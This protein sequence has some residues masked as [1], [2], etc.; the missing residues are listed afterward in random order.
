[1]IPSGLFRHGEPLA[2]LQGSGLYKTRP[3]PDAGLSRVN[4]EG[5][6]ERSVR[7]RS[8]PTNPAR[9]TERGVVVGGVT[10]PF[11]AF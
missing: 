6:L 10:V 1:M 9:S 7:M 11:R 3:L 5:K 8:T 4:C 2:R